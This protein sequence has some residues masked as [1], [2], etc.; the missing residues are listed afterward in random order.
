MGRI[1]NSLRRRG[2]KILVT[3]RCKKACSGCNQLCNVIPPEK[4]WDI[5]LD[6]L[7]HNINLCAKFYKLIHIFGG[8]PVQHPQWAKVRKLLISYNV[9]TNPTGKNISF[10]VSTDRYKVHK[11]DN[12]IYYAAGQQHISKQQRWFH[13]TLVAPCDVFFIKN[14]W[15][16]ARK[17]CG[18]WDDNNCH[19]I[20]YNNK[21]YFCQ[22]A[23]AFDWLYDIGYGW[24]LKDGVNPF[25][26]TDEEIAEQ[27]EHYCKRCGFLC[28][29]E[30]VGQQ[31]IRQPNIITKTNLEE[32]PDCIKKGVK[33]KLL[34]FPETDKETA[35]R[36][37]THL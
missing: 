26:R 21:V 37:I 8:E 20:I 34:S 3:N 6:Q 36:K 4:V 24:P 16:H 32:L 18:M 23:G 11:Y 1:A 7:E 17:F 25:N 31:R 12:N 13:P 10:V 9:N 29:T 5:S 19:G 2:P 15:Q 33:F 27:A 22:N 28:N 14:Y 30:R 35:L